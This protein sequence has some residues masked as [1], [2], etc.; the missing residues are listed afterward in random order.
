MCPCCFTF[1]RLSVSLNT[2]YSAKLLGLCFSHWKYGHSSLVLKWRRLSI[3]MLFARSS[4]VNLVLGVSTVSV[5]I[6][7]SSLDSIWHSFCYIAHPFAI[8][9]SSCSPADM[10]SI[11]VMPLHISLIH[12]HSFLPHLFPYLPS[13]L[14]FLI[15]LWAE[16][17]RPSFLPIRPTICRIWH[18]S[19]IILDHSSHWYAYRPMNYSRVL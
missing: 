14:W 10:S 7:P 6:V 19:P 5:F 2:S 1:A 12:R 3:S 18:L 8:T 4:I 13:R 9:P 16:S 11:L 15:C 17:H